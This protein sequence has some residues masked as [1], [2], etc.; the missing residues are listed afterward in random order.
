MHYFN[1]VSKLLGHRVLKTTQIY[2]KVIDSNKR[3]AVD[4]IQLSIT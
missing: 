1:T 4:K 2:T 3:K